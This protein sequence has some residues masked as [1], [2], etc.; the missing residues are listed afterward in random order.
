MSPAYLQTGLGM[1][2]KKSDNFK[3]NI[4]PVTGKLILV[5]KQ[6][7]ETSSLFGVAQGE[8][9]R[10]EIGASVNVYS[11]N[12]IFKNV[13][14]ENILN[15]YSNY[16][17]DAQ[18]VDVD[19]TI[20]IVMKINNYMSTNIAFQTIYDDNAISAAQVKE[21]FGLGVNYGF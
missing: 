7:T 6:F 17:E 19:Y 21:V 13:T 15:L 16:I 9:I 11:K 12:E 3:L 10:R 5:D 8:T 14:L 2:Y 18:N 4:A 1:L 20:N